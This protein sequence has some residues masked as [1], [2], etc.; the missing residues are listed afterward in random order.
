M[1]TSTVIK[2]PIWRSKF[3]SFRPGIHSKGVCNICGIHFNPSSRYVRFCDSC[4]EES[5]VY[6][7]AGW[8]LYS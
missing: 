4:R 2:K 7:H 1:N 5:E 8:A 6:K 3:E